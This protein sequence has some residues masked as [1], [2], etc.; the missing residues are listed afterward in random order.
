[1]KKERIRDRGG[2]PGL[3]GMMMLGMLVV[4]DFVQSG[5]PTIPAALAPSTNTPP[6]VYQP[7]KT[8]S[9]GLKRQ[10]AAGSRAGSDSSVSLTALVPNGLPLCATEQPIFWWSLSAPTTHPVEFSL[11]LGFKTRL[12]KVLAGPI[13]AGL[14]PIDLATLAKDHRLIPGEHYQWAVRLKVGDDPALHPVSMGWVEYRPTDPKLAARASV[15]SA[16]Q[17]AA[18]FAEEGYWYDA[19]TLLA[20]PAP[21]PELGPLLRQAGL[22]NVVLSTPK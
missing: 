9:L 8:R 10:V 3:L 14:H 12:K 2:R 17:Q 21:T 22:T 1:M 19:V 7:S 4:C 6:V 5:E 16:V 13:N 20:T 15:G 18:V 11:N